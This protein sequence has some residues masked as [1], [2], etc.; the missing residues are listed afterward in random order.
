MG[1]ARVLAM[2]ISAFALLHPLAALADDTGPAPVH[3][4]GWF[5][6]LP[7]RRI[8]DLQA[9]ALSGWPDLFGPHG[10]YPN[11]RLSAGLSF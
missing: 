8:V 6:P 3:T 2:S 1:R 7:F 4:T 5:E 9:S 11:A 10:V